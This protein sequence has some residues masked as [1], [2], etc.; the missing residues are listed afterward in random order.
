[1]VDKF[2]FYRKDEIEENLSNVRYIYVL[3]KK[4]CSP[5]NKLKCIDVGIFVY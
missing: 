1:M 4:I 5:G 2:I 3:G